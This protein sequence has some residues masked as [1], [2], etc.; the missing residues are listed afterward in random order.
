MGVLSLIAPIFSLCVPILTVFTVHFTVYIT[1]YIHKLYIQ[2]FE[3]A[4][5]EFK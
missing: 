3:L 5:S 4:L 1:Y 2:D